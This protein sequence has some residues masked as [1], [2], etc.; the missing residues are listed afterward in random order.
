LS[1]LF[2]KVT[3]TSC[4]FTSIVQC[5]HIAAGRRIQAG[6]TTNGVINKT[7]RLR[8]SLQI[9]QGSVATHLRCDGI[10]SDSII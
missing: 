2:S 8:Q 7:L 1:Q 6:D 3:V 9:S 5:V 4:I 10:F